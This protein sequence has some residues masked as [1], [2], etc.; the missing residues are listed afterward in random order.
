MKQKSIESLD[1]PLVKKWVRL[2]K[3]RSEREKESSALVIGSHVI[4]ELMH[5]QRPRSI[6]VRKGAEIPLSDSFFEASDEVIKKIADLPML[7]DWIAEFPIDTRTEFK[8]CQ[9]LLILDQIK[10]PG[11]LGTLLRT[12][13]AFGW[14]HVFLL[15]GSADPFGEKAL[16]A[17][18]G[19]CFLLEMKNGSV[20]EL[21]EL[22][23]KQKLL[24]LV[25]DLEGKKPEDIKELSKIALI[26]GSEVS[27]VSDALTKWGEKV[28]LPMAHGS[29]SLNVAIAGAIL[30]Y[31]WRV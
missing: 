1:N 15:E 11:N 9:R 26:L 30:M 27:G 7:P 3:K 16:Q 19:A 10:D 20:L 12:A 4:K 25:A 2:R 28:S 29:E 6:L 23:R 14:R 24:V 31:Q 21:E 5:T 18:K 17:S 22:V 13:H 8:N